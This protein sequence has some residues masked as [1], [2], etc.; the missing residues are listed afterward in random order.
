MFFSVLHP[1]FYGCFDWH[2]SVHGHW[3]LALAL[4]QYPNT[5]LAA[6]IT[7]GNLISMSN[8]QIHILIF[9]VFNAQFKKEK[10]DKEIEYFEKEHHKSF[11]RTYG[12]AWLLK[13][14]VIVFCS[15]NYDVVDLLL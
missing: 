1:I 7:E 15:Q 2:S 11:E 14:Q 8:F 10:V 6:N 3:L 12:W 9:S 5:E 13:L 4:S